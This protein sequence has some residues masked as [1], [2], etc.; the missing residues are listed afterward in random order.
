MFRK[1]IPFKFAPFLLSVFIMM[2]GWANAAEFLESE[3]FEDSFVTED[4]LGHSFEDEKGF[5]EENNFFDSSF[6]DL[7]IA[8]SRSYT[9]SPRK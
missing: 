9:L 5:K 3:F 4:N 7:K 1:L 6:N 2:G 8:D